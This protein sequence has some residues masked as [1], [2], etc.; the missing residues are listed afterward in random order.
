MEDVNLHH[1]DWNNWTTNPSK[2]VINLAKWVANQEAFYQFK[3][4][5]I[6]HNR[7]GAIDLVIASS[8]MTPNITE[9]Y[10][11]PILHTTSNHRTIVTTIK[12]ESAPWESNTRLVGFYLSR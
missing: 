5:T 4:G 3:P 7:Q 12:L 10:T 2:G 6:T 1:I 9:C 11:E 8:I